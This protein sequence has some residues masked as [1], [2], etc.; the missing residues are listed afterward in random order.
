MNA[1]EPFTLGTGE[2]NLRAADSTQAMLAPALSL[3]SS[4]GPANLDRWG[5]LERLEKVG[6]GL[7]GQ[8][9]RA[10]D[11]QLQREVALKLCRRGRSVEDE[12][13]SLVLQEARVLA[14]IRHPNVVTVYGIDKYGGWLGVCMEY[15]R[16]KTLEALLAE[17]GR[18]AA[19]EA[20]LIGLDLCSALVV[21]HGLGLLHRDIN[22]KNAMR[23]DRGRIVL[24]DFGLSQDLRGR[25]ACEEAQE[26]C[27]T[28]LY[29]APELLRGEKAS[30]QSDIFGLGVLLYRLVT[31]RFP[32]EGRNFSD[33][34][35]AYER[36]EAIRL[37]DRRN[38][39]PEPF[40]RA[41][42]RALAADPHDRF[43]TA[44]QM[45]KALISSFT[46]EMPRRRR[47]A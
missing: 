39:L 33:L 18:L 23:E 7:S 10:W 40:V 37:R 32:V 30:A 24:M 29:M 35:R 5:R 41:V 42:E 15:I 8:V 31:D 36:G 14:R 12:T 34:R 47:G 16:G 22:A 9:F 25:D 13:Y 6:Q 26:I 21:I 2:F 38:A 11:P 1:R 43:A 46:V 44:G 17:Q 4:G 19:R 3:C 45:A 28:P 27:G 20:A